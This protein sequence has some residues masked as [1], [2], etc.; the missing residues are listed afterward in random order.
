[1]P[2]IVNLKLSQ[3]GLILVCVPLAF[4]LIFVAVLTVLLLQAESETKRAKHS[5][6]L[7][8]QANSVIQTIY[9]GAV[10]LTGYVMTSGGAVFELRYR[11]VTEEIS[12]ELTDFETLRGDNPAEQEHLKRARILG[13]QSLDLL[14]ELKS[15]VD[16]SDTNSL[17]FAA[18]PEAVKGQ[19]DRLKGRFEPLMGQLTSE[20][21]KTIE[22]H[23]RSESSSEKKSAQLLQAVMICLGIGVI[24]N[25][26]LA[27]ALADFFY[28][29]TAS[30]LAVLTD[31][32]KRL[33]KGQS[34][35]P[36]LDGE[37]EIAN[38]DHK[39]H[40]LAVALKEVE[41]LK[42]EFYAMVTHDLRSPL[43]SIRGTFGLL[44]QGAYGEIP[45]LAKTKCE[46]AENNVI[47]MVGLVNDL[48]DIE[49]IEA[50]K[51]ELSLDTF[52]I[53]EVVNSSIDSVQA[54]AQQKE[55]T[56]DHEPVDVEIFAD[57]R[58]L[59]QVL[60][61]LLSNAIKFSPNKS[62]VVVSVKQIP[63]WVEVAVTDQGRGIPKDDLS[64][65]FNKFEQVSVTDATLKGGTGLGLAVCKGIIEEHKGTIGV[66]SEEGKGTTF[67]FRIPSLVGAL[68]VS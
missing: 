42:R 1:M 14:A 32:T 63:G 61:N 31:N 15:Y 58:R 66:E 50:G 45:D 53:S 22:S 60:V 16:D 59:I 19:L 56:I 2:D 48:L 12:K 4:E 35:N 51:W 38:L 39:F 20:L 68:Q 25:I 27:F 49:K 7:I 41:R 28:K 55:I 65:V 26:A 13:R 62:T 23:K 67:W 40:D 8:S 44:I 18:N 57:A 36:P 46:R 47:R 64:K 33:E 11:K 9:Q 21:N 30:R 54:L 37:D 24:F 52:P 3:K 29:G 17:A 43:T 5:Q 6:A 10:A 34:L